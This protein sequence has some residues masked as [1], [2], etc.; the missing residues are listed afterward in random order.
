MLSMKADTLNSDI[1]TP[2]SVQYKYS[3]LICILYRTPAR[4]YADQLAVN[5]TF[6]F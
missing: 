1:N 2:Y 3:N 4:L 5:F 6:P